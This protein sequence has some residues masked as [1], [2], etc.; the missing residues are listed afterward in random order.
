[1]RKSIL[2]LAVSLLTACATSKPAPVVYDCPELEV[3]P[4]PPAAI[5]KLTAISRP[6][7][8]MKAYVKTVRD[9]R[10]WIQVVEAEVETSK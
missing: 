7:E 6:D 8:V 10:S 3:P 4:E 2:I 1:M 9:Y 5:H